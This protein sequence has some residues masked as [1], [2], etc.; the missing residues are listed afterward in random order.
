MYIQHPTR[1]PRL[2]TYKAIEILLVLAYDADHRH[3]WR[4]T[5]RIIRNASFYEI[6]KAIQRSPDAKTRAQLCYLLG[7]KSSRRNTKRTQVELPTLIKCLNDESRNVRCEAADAIYS[8]RAGPALLQHLETEQDD[9]VRS[10]LACVLGGNQY[11]PAI[12]LLV[13]LLPDKSENVRSMVAWALGRLLAHEAVEPLRQALANETEAYPKSNMRGALDEIETHNRKLQTE[14]QAKAMN[15]TKSIELY[16]LAQKVIPGGVNSPVRAFRGVGGTPLFIDHAKGAYIWDA[17]GNR[18]IDYVLSWGPLVLGHAPDAVVEAIREQ[19]GRGT[20]FGA[21]TGL[22]TQLAE[23]INVRIPSIQLVRFVNSGTEATMSALRLAR[24][25]TGRSKIVKF[26]GHYHGHSDMLL[27]QAGSGVATLGLPDSPGVP[28]GATQDTL[29]LPFNELAVVETLFAQF[30]DQIAA[31]IMEPVAGNMGFVLPQPGY[32]QGIR[33]LTR[34]HGAVLIFDEVMTG[35]RVALGGAQEKYGVTPDLTT[36][37]KV[38]GG[39]LPVGA[40]GGRADIMRMVAPSGPMYQ[41]GTLSGNPLAMTAGIVTLNEWSVPG[42]FEGVEACTSE[43]VAGISRIARAAG[44]PVQAASVGTMF[45]FF[46]AEQPILDYQSA[47]TSDTVRYAKAFHA[48]LEQGVYLAP[49]QFES[50]FVSTAHTSEVIAQTLQ[51]FE[52]AIK[53]LR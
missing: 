20:S 37:G 31:V 9:G 8:P 38:I 34:K 41:A 52:V 29:T 46:F 2:R 48:L 4:R 28:Q 40:Y 30:P 35:F 6:T 18:F 27:V 36:L 13:E 42:V 39:G 15:I 45:G 21:P 7:K 51:A 44:I 25:F 11:H 16:A 43:L 19:A 10:M 3:T 49:S 53:G 26:A 24:A 33:D 50:G 23:Q 22:E 1:F 17:D 5:H 14:A 47:K 12:P 32:L